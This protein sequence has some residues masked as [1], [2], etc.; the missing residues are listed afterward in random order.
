[1]ATSSRRSEGGHHDEAELLIA[2]G[3]EVVR[4]PT[5]PAS[6]PVFAIPRTKT[7]YVRGEPPVEVVAKALA[8]L[9]EG[10]FQNPKPVQ[11]FLIAAETLLAQT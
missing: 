9:A 8:E 2:A 7:L 6:L 3:Y 1:M 10:F 4:A 5:L 11:A